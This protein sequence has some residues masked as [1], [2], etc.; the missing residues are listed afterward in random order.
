MKVLRFVTHAWSGIVHSS[1]KEFVTKERELKTT[2]SVTRRTLSDLFERQGP[3]PPTKHLLTSV[4]K[5]KV[6][7][8]G[9]QLLL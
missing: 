2:F 4:R 6:Y 1:V 9:L 7:L 3:T 8:K 5:M